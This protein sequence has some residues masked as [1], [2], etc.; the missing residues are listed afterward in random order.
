MRIVHTPYE[1]IV[2]DDYLLAPIFQAVT[3]NGEF[4]D[5]DHIL[6]W[7][8]EY[9]PHIFG[10]WCV[11]T[12]ERRVEIADTIRDVIQ[13]D[14]MLTISKP[15]IPDRYELYV[16]NIDKKYSNRNLVRN[17]VMS[18]GGIAY[19][20]A[21]T[22]TSKLTVVEEEDLTGTAY[23]LISLLYRYENHVIDE[24]SETISNMTD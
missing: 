21:A 14:R 19:Y 6:K 10:E 9:I 11:C 20:E 22:E 17:R 16:L 3:L 18:M 24:R 13:T 4:D 15:P 7:L 23:A 12:Q 2:R 1:A 8:N 5:D